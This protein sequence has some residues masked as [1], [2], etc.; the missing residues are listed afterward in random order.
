MSSQPST[1]ARLRQCLRADS[2]NPS[3][4]SRLNRAFLASPTTDLFVWD[5][6]SSATSFAAADWDL[7]SIHKADA[8]PADSPAGRALDVGIN[9][10]TQP[11]SM[12]PGC[13]NGCRQDAHDNEQIG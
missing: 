10:L 12:R 1:A 9:S 8:A 5:L 3:K 7:A 6:A 2:L 13:R 11:V 4:P